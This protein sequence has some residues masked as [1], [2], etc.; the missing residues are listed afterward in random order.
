MA[1]GLPNAD[2]FAMINRRR[3]CGGEQLGVIETEVTNLIS[4][5]GVNVEAEKWT[6]RR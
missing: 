6:Q 4:F 1:C 5:L 3:R 2:K